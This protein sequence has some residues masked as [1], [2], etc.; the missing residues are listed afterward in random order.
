[1]WFIVVHT[2]MAWHGIAGGGG[3][4]NNKFQI[5]TYYE[6]GWLALTIWAGSVWSSHDFSFFMC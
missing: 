2:R 4:L 5:F 1:M 6:A 3:E